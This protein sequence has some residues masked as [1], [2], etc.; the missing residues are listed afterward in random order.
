MP[1]KPKAE[2][3]T[4]FV[5]DP[6]AVFASV[7]VHFP[8]FPGVYFPGEPIAARELLDRLA[9]VDTIE[10]L[11]DHVAAEALPLKVKMVDEGSAPMPV[12]ETHAPS[13]E[14]VRKGQ[15]EAPDEPMPDGELLPEGTPAAAI[16]EDQADEED[17]S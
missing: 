4:A 3:E 16:A 10:A 12:A 8:N 5:L 9:D 11:K 14:E 6:D 15:A 13:E 7:P 17:K 2:Q 1:S